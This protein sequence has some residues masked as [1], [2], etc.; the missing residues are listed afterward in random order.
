MVAVG[1]R[2]GT[3]CAVAADEKLAT[4]RAS[5][6]RARIALIKAAPRD[7]PRN[8]TDHGSGSPSRSPAAIPVGIMEPAQLKR[9]AGETTAYLSGS[10]PAPTIGSRGG[11][12]AESTG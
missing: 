2:L 10:G 9:P 4:S 12:T 3:A 8:S 7:T 5:A 11:F 1:A 6:S